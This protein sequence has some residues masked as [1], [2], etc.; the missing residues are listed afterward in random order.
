MEVILPWTFRFF[1][2]FVVLAV[3]RLDPRV[4]TLS[5]HFATELRFQLESS[6]FTSTWIVCSQNIFYLTQN[7]ESSS[8]LSANMR[9]SVKSFIWPTFLKDVRW[10]TR[11]AQS[12]SSLKPNGT[13]PR[14]QL[15]VHRIQRYSVLPQGSY[16]TLSLPPRLKLLYFSRPRT[17]HFRYLPG[18]C[19]PPCCH[20]AKPS[21]HFAVC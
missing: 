19:F 3:R 2:F 5:L 16:L 20:T 8:S 6:V 15:S 13:R 12:L 1:S 17:G 18:S 14:P 9:C 7:V 11:E 4:L 21:V 10:R